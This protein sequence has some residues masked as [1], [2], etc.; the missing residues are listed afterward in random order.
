MKF[1]TTIA[2]YLIVYWVGNLIDLL[3]FKIEPEKLDNQLYAVLVALAYLIIAVTEPKA[4]V[5]PLMKGDN[6]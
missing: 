4:N 5:P 2:V 1:L 6:E 3:L